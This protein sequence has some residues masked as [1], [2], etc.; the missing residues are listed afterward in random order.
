[1]PLIQRKRRA[2]GTR[3]HSFEEVSL[4][5]SSNPRK[6]TMNLKTNHPDL[7]RRDDENKLHQKTMLSTAMAV[8]RQTVAKTKW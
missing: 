5:I 6:R 4:T 7:R 1:M 3:K 8:L 2:V